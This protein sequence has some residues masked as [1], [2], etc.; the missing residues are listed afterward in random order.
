MAKRSPK[1]F[2]AGRTAGIRPGDRLG[3]IANEAGIHSQ[4]IGP[5]KIENHFLLVRVL[6]EMAQ[7]VLKALSR[8]RLKGKKVTVRINHQ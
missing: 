7:G 8:T 3:A 4:M 5:I 1:N 6:E 2:H